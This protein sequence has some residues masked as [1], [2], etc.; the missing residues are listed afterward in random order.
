MRTW[1]MSQ[2]TWEADLLLR[3]FET[4]NLVIF[5]PDITKENIEAAVG[6]LRR[7]NELDRE[8]KFPTKFIERPTAM[9][10]PKTRVNPLIHQAMM[11]VLSS[12]HVQ[13]PATP[14][15]VQPSENTPPPVSP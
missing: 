11:G 13:E 4:G 6:I 15:P 1:R 10:I 14:R 8:K 5:R 2:R 7:D 3:E 12:P 9:I